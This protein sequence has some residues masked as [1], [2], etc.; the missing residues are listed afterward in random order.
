MK[1]IESSN[2]NQ[3]QKKRINTWWRR[4]AESRAQR[5]RSRPRCREGEKK[6]KCGRFE[7]QM[8]WGWEGKKKLWDSLIQRPWGMSLSWVRW[9]RRAW[10]KQ[11]VW[12]EA[13]VRQSVF[14]TLGLGL[15]FRLCPKRC[16]FRLEKVKKPKLV[17]NRFGHAGSLFFS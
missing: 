7:I 17:I 1:E 4:E 3:N 12:D 5:A 14:R 16:S 15:V 9:E 6:K 10:V 13:W 11:W 8:L 2:Q